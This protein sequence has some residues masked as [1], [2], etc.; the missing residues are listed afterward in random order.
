[1]PTEITI[2]NMQIKVIE[3]VLA[4]WLLGGCY[5]ET[6]AMI[7]DL[8]GPPAPPLEVAPGQ[9]IT[10]TQSGVTPNAMVTF[11][12]DYQARP[13]WCPPSN[14]CQIA[15]VAYQTNLG[16]VRADSFGVAE[17]S[18]IIPDLPPCAPL[19]FQALIRV[20]TP[21]LTSEPKFAKLVK[22]EVCNGVD[23]NCDNDVD[24]NPADGSLWYIDGDADAWGSGPAMMACNAPPGRVGREGDCDDEDPTNSP[25][26]A[27]RCDGTDNNCDGVIDAD[28]IDRTGQ[29]FDGDGD[30][31]GSGEATLQCPGTQGYATTAGDCNDTTSTTNPNQ[32]ERCDGLDQDC[33]GQ[34]DNNPVDPRTW[35]ADSDLDG[36]GSYPVQACA[37]PAGSVTEPGDCDDTRSTAFPGA[38][39]R[40]NGRDDN[41]NSVV[42]EATATDA[43]TW[44]F[45]GDQDTFGD[46]GISVQACSQPAGYAANPEDCNDGAPAIHP[47]NADVCDGLDNDC[48]GAVDDDIIAMPTFFLDGDDDGF[49]NPSVAFVACQPPSSGTWVTNPFD[50]ADDNTLIQ[51]GGQEV[52]D[53][54][55]RDEDCDGFADDFDSSA[56]PAT[57]R[58]F[59]PDSDFDGFGDDHAADILKC[60]PDFDEVPTLGDCDDTN[61][62]V[63]PGA[64]DVPADDLDANCDGAEKCYCNRD[65][66]AYGDGTTLVERPYSPADV[67]HV[68][69]PPASPPSFVASSCGA[70]DANVALQAGDCDDT[71]PATGD[72]PTL[73]FYDGDGDLEGTP[74]VSQ[75]QCS[76][77]GPDWTPVG[78]DCDDSNTDINR[79]HGAQEVCDAANKDED[80]DGLVDDADTSVVAA[81]KG[82]WY[83]DGDGDR[84]GSSSTVQRCDPTPTEA[85]A[86]GDCNDADARVNPA[87]IEIVADNIDGDCDGRETCYCN[88]DGDALGISSS[89]VSKGITTPPPAGNVCSP[90]P[91]PPVSPAATCSAATVAIVAGDCNDSNKNS[92]TE[93]SFQFFDADNDGFGDPNVY[94]F[95]C[96]VPPGAWVTN[97]DDCDDDDN[98]IRPTASEVCDFVDNNCDG[99]ID[100]G[101]AP[102]TSWAD[103]DSD[104]YGDPH[105]SWQVCFVTPGW[106]GNPDDCNDIREDIHPAGAEICDGVDNDCSGE[107]DDNA[108]NAI[109]WVRDA[110]GDGFGDPLSPPKEACDQPYGYTTDQTDCDDS[111]AWVYPEAGEIDDDRDNNCD[112]QVDN[113]TANPTDQHRVTLDTD[114]LHTCGILDDGQ[115]RCF[116][117]NDSGQLGAGHNEHVGDDAQE[118]GDLL[119]P[120]NLGAGRTAIE[121]ATGED[122]T[123]ALLDNGAVRCWGSNNQG[124]LGY[125]TDSDAPYGTIEGVLFTR[126]EAD[127]TLLLANT[128]DKVTLDDTVRLDRRAAENIVNGRPFTNLEALARVDWVGA[129]ALTRMRDWANL[130]PPS[131]LLSDPVVHLGA[132]ITAVQ[133]GT[134]ERF[135]CARLSD[136][137]VK[138]WGRNNYGQLGIGST[139]T[140]GDGPGELGDMLAPVALG[141]NRTAVDLA[142]GR[143]H[144]CVLLSDGMVKCWGRNDFGQL[145]YG[146]DANLGDSPSEMGDNLPRVQLGSGTVVDVEVGTQHSCARFMDGA[147]KCWGRNDFGQLGLGDKKHRGDGPNEMGLNLPY[148]DVGT[149]AGTRRTV[150]EVAPGGVHT[151]AILNRATTKCWGYGWSTGYGPGAPT[152]GDEPNEMGKNLPEVPLPAPTDQISAGLT[153]TCVVT[154]CGKSFCWGSNNLYGQLGT[155]D[156]ISYDQ[157]TVAHTW[158]QSRYIHAA[159]AETCSNNQRP[160]PPTLDVRRVHTDEGTALICEVVTPS[161]D[162]EGDSVRYV[163]EWQL[164]GQPYSGPTATSQIPGDTVIIDQV[165]PQTWTC[166]A[167]PHDRF[168]PGTPSTEDHITYEPA[169]TLVDTWGDHMCA[170]LDD[171]SV[172]CFGSNTYGQLGVGNTLARGDAPDELGN[173]AVPVDIGDGRT[174]KEVATGRYHTCVLLDDGSVRCWGRN[175][176]GELGT[177]TSAQLGDAP[178]EVGDD[179]INPTVNLGA[180]RT[181]VHI[182]AGAAMSCAVLDNGQV[183][184]WGASAD[185]RIGSATDRGLT[186]ASMGDNLPPVDLGANVRAIDV[187]AGDDHACALLD[188]GRIK[189]WGNNAEGK[190]GYGDELSR[191]LTPMGDDLHEVNLAGGP[192]VEVEAGGNHTCARFASGK[193]KCWGDNSNGQLGYEHRF[194]LG[195]EGG[196]A[197]M[198]VNLPYVN[199]GEGRTAVALQAG[200]LHTCAVLDNGAVKCWGHQSGL[201]YDGTTPRGGAAGEMGDHLPEIA[202]PGGEARDVAAGEHDACAITGCGALYCWGSNAAGESATGAAADAASLAT[203]APTVP[204]DFGRDRHITTPMEEDCQANTAPSAPAIRITRSSAVG[205]DLVCEV[206][207]PSNDAEDHP[208]RYIATWTRDGAPLTHRATTTTFTHDTVP[209]A[210][211]RTAL[212][213]CTVTPND[214][215]TSGRAAVERHIVIP[216]LQ[217]RLLDISGADPAAEPVHVCAVLETGAVACYGGN[218]QGQ[219]GVGHGYPVGDNV[220]EMGDYLSYVNLGND[221]TARSVACGYAH[222]CAVL[223][224]GTVR[225][226]G[227]AFGNGNRND[228]GDNPGEVGNNT[229]NPVVDLGAGVTVEQVSAGE[230]FTCARLM[231]GRVKCWGLS[232][233]RDRVIGGETHELGDNLPA[234]NLGPGRT[235]VD[236]TAAADMAC[237]LLDNGD[238]K[239]WY[240][241]GPALRYSVGPSQPL[242]CNERVDTGSMMQDTGSVDADTSGGIASDEGLVGN[243]TPFIPERSD[244][245][246]GI[247]SQGDRICTIDINNT[248]KC[249]DVY[250]QSSY[251]SDDVYDDAYSFDALSAHDIIAFAEGARNRCVVTEC[252]SVWCWGN[253]NYGQL[254]VNDTIPR[255]EAEFP[256]NLGEFR[257][258]PYQS[259][260]WYDCNINRRPSTPTV[261][262]V[263]LGPSAADGLRCDLVTPSRDI[264]GDTIVYGIEWTKDG[265]PWGDLITTELADDTVPPEEVSDGLWRCTITPYDEEGPGPSASESHLVAPEPVRK[266]V[267]VGGDFTCAILN[268]GGVRCVGANGRGQLGRGDTTSIGDAPGETGDSLIPVNLGAGRTA[269][270]IS[271]GN[272]HTCALLDNGK[273][274][275][276]GGNAYGE[277]G[278]GNTQT[279]GDNAG[280]VGNNSINPA[281]NLGTN[282]IAAQIGTGAGF[283]CARLTDGRVKCWGYGGD[284]RTGQGHTLSLGDTPTE[285]GDNLPA[286]DLGSRRVAF[287]LTVG[288]RHA[289]ALL[290]NGTVKCWGANELSELG[291]PDRRS[292]GDAPGEM[293]NPLHPVR[294]GP[295]ALADVEAGSRH[296]CARFLNGRVKCWGDNSFGQLGIQSTNIP[297]SVESENSYVDLGFDRKAI[298]LT[299][300][301][302]HTCAVLDGGAA[303]CWGQSES[304]GYNNMGH[305]GNTANMGDLLPAL[306]IGDPVDAVFAGGE[307]STCVVTSCGATWCWGQNQF[308]QLGLGHTT[309]TYE[310]T[311]PISWGTSRYVPTQQAR[312]CNAVPVATSCTIRPTSPDTTNTLTAEANGVAE[313]GHTITWSYVW[314]R[315]NTEGVTVYPP[316][317]TGTF[318]ASETTRGDVIRVTCIPSDGP[319]TGYPMTSSDVTIL[320]SPPVAQACSL[321]PA[322]PTAGGPLRVVQPLALDADGDVLN[323]SYV[324]T[325]N[326][327]VEEGVSGDVWDVQKVPGDRISVVCIPSDA[328]GPGVALLSDTVT[329]N[330]PP[331]LSGCT[332]TPPSPNDDQDLVAASVATDA[333]GDLITRTWSW[334]RNDGTIETQIPG[335]FPATSTSPGDTIT[336][337]CQATD[338]LEDVERSASV[339]IGAASITLAV[340][341]EPSAA[342]TNDQLIADVDATAQDG[343]L[344]TLS[345]AWY[346]NG[347]LVIGATTN[348]LEP[349]RFDKGDVVQVEVTA[350][351][352]HGAVRTAVA[353]ITIRNTRP[354]LSSCSVTPTS[355]G[356]SQDWTASAVGLSDDDPEDAGTLSASVRWQKRFGPLW[357]DIPGETDLTLD[358]CSDRYTPGGIYNCSHGDQIRAICRAYDGDEY[359]LDYTSATI[360][361]GNARPTVTQCSLSPGGPNTNQDIVATA[362]AQDLDADP[363]IFSY[364]WYKNGSVDNSVTGPTY[365]AS[366][367]SHFDVF[368]V[369][370]TARDSQGDSSSPVSSAPVSV[371]NTP[372]GAPIIDLTPNAPR[373]DQ[374]LTATITTPAT[375]IDGDAVVYDLYWTRQ[376]SVFANPT[377]PTTNT[378]VEKSATTRGETWEV[379]AVSDDGYSTGGSDSD[380]VV[381]QNTPPTVAL[382]LLLPTNPTTTSDVEVFGVGFFDDDFDPEDYLVAWYVNGAIQAAQAPNPMVLNDTAILRGDIV[383]ATLTAKDPFTTGNT[384]TTSTITVVNTRPTAPVLAITPNPPGENDPLT[385]TITSPSTDADG[386]TITYTY[387]WYR[388]GSV[389]MGQTTNTFGAALTSF[390]EVYHCTVTPNDGTAVGAIGTSPTVAIQDLNAPPAPTVASVYYR[391]NNTTLETLSGTCVS[392]ALNCN[393]VRIT[394]NDGVATDIYNTP[395]T[396]NAFSQI[397]STDRSLTT[398]C[399]AAC[400]DSSNNPSSASNAFA[401]TSCDPYD[402]YEDAGSYGDIGTNPVS[403]WSTLADNNSSS[404][405]ITANI[406]ADD[407]VDWYRIMTSDNPIADAVAGANAFKFEVE[408]TLGDAD[409]NIW[410]YKTNP[411][412]TPYCVAT[413]PYDNFSIDWQDRADAPNHPLPGNL[414]ACTSNG[415]AV[416]S[417]YNQCSSLGGDYYLRVL[418]EFDTDC[419]PYQLRVYN[420][421]P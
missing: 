20:S 239:C 95:S 351:D 376:G 349:G 128:A 142:V 185:G 345:Y 76:R 335:T 188:N 158:G 133:V 386:D 28:A 265:E 305:R 32:P 273:V 321:A 1:M 403:E 168:G 389:V 51:P 357:Q 102:T 54:S 160:G 393:T 255:E 134:G 289:C 253:N 222:T 206:V 103:V 46:P 320:N 404:I 408:M 121:V 355:G 302:F 405:T 313:L 48:N 361:I 176:R 146:H 297:T 163:M 364:E 350:S 47:G 44:Y 126:N 369:R 9:Q 124:Q 232:G 80:C 11:I 348:T 362:A 219:L 207:T 12:A 16:T 324:W 49:G 123:C 337:T 407:T 208:I 249:Y 127:L 354:S 214:G 106:V 323:W 197:E 140:V 314:Q 411:A 306:A 383:Y 183:K 234:I 409:Y 259:P 279:I 71:N 169:A 166:R 288:K 317:P 392:G 40:C 224:N 281:V 381:I 366:K 228:I 384:V 229:L 84:Y 35:Y 187:S 137:S 149:D 132:G 261:Q 356:M 287:D 180:G 417:L 138:C 157:A 94:I 203:A 64:F 303:K 263:R 300:G 50:C 162:L 145:G 231:D 130:N 194:D 266:L 247:E 387:A 274:Q 45:D 59:R 111:D 26:A 226:W 173:N 55:N 418:R 13:T 89:L 413:G 379:T 250:N 190:L 385:C 15:M 388:N 374:D 34:I 267:A 336:V 217:E 242:C 81:T 93:A 66:D 177:G 295:D 136:G 257:Y 90:P 330:H 308:G 332:L 365:P 82:T 269:L 211:V 31:F 316:E 252:G 275:C 77:P 390:G 27:E 395:C 148:V 152:R 110:D 230:D 235:A 112:G 246:V 391:Y 2:N 170:V 144:V 53:P 400:Y 378:L 114:G 353:E 104:G 23:D 209:A 358:S 315:D 215:L 329:I 92:L 256:V 237:A 165:L 243:E 421:R 39:E 100:E 99:A 210:E 18:T 368:Q 401:K 334:T 360:V 309:Q 199:L 342:K 172:R 420:G 240:S 296:T 310:P 213:T 58:T 143:F 363:V 394:C 125:L 264:D 340:T 352:S 318:P 272:T 117:R 6:P 198:D 78:T 377:N 233:Y 236:I 115:V 278:I 101:V 258:V 201:G 371:V 244:I 87:A 135:S 223:D 212:Y 19:E 205:F 221:R 38:P 184:C 331:V 179:L 343:G 62:A 285:L 192:V 322:R 118:M 292:R 88:K 120:V 122:H 397:V 326:G 69:A 139:R 65:G 370:C 181:A 276:W 312:E 30:G 147:L 299:V 307:D 79:T 311:A 416:W 271:A 42:D 402:P 346:V 290:D 248:S 372:P 218:E 43:R 7:L 375:D 3:I 415:S 60:D 186:V 67:T 155:E 380:F 412:S 282:A 151:C 254:G 238:I 396:A 161:S 107:T 116:G 56:S 63:K 25:G 97:P 328:A 41:C 61:A 175:Q 156:T 182:D 68:C 344:V 338:G 220:E 280:E 241:A 57:F 8:A 286:V 105:V 129:D 131:T 37:Q 202:L 29:F 373:S 294:L 291:L 73:W 225:C 86:T 24:N 141:T 341:L 227:R 33:D 195:D 10:L 277:L 359:G 74:S 283:S 36:V 14:R 327:V 262:I 108:T 191:G 251:F 301:N 75:L 325:R 200:A 319:V 21:P 4:A 171:G 270:E 98:T 399:S 150:L 419:Q 154:V 22:P 5:S 339:I 167:T 119:T 193:I 406:V 159:A 367:T 164:D 298:A 304:I 382:A 398:T 284:G 347:D 109:L 414:N 96:Y 204:V 196:D 174:A 189:C 85:A 333:D 113:T 83:T 245:F 17:T 91:M 260:P 178:H 72:T 410:V 52:C 70:A 268:D 216:P 153:N 293:G